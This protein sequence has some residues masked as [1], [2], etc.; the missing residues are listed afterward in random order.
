[1]QRTNE[2]RATMFRGDEISLE[3]EEMCLKMLS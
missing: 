2:S 3:I 1:M